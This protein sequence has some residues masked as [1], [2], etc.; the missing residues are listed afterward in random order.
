M[1]DSPLDRR[2]FFSQ[3]LRKVLGRAVD[4]M[5]ERMARRRYV[6]PPGALSEAPFLAACTRCGECERVCPVH[7]IRPLGTEHGLAAGT[8][9]LELNLTAC[10]MCADMPCAAACPTDALAVPDDVWHSVK[11]S[12]VAIDTE[13]CITYR[14]VSCGVCARACPVGESAL[15]IDAAGHPV[16]GDACTGCGACISS[17]VTSPSSIS[18]TPPGGF[19]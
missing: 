18:A 17:C 6:R 15:A 5:S 3:G 13:C 2:A 16:L 9:A 14:D 4:T 10:I 12:W 1:P 8:P 7:A 11:M 19:Q